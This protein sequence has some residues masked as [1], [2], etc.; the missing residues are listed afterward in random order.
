[1]QRMRIEQNTRH[2]GRYSVVGKAR[3]YATKSDL[4]RALRSFTKRQGEGRTRVV[5]V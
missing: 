2:G 5:S 1:M 4:K 3:G